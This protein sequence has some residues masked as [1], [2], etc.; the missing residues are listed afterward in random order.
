MTGHMRATLDLA[1]EPRL[2]FPTAVIASHDAGGVV[3]VERR[4]DGLYVAAKKVVLFRSELQT[5]GVQGPQLYDEL[6]GKP[7]LNANV[8]HFLMQNS[9]FIPDGPDWRK[10]DEG[11]DVMIYFWGTLFAHPNGDHCVSH[12]E[13]N[14]ASWN[15]S[16]SSI[17][18]WWLVH[19]PAALLEA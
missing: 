13:W 4:A 5:A 9:E 17:Q 10:Q 2:P 1:A 19:Q 6:F 14:G 18:N 8:L 3:D 7:V 15:W 11:E 16:C 12:M